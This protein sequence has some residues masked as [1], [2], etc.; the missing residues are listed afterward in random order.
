MDKES[1][2][3]VTLEDNF[4]ASAHGSKYKNKYFRQKDKKSRHHGDGEAR[5][6][7]GFVVWGTFKHA[8]RE[9]PATIEQLKSERIYGVFVNDKLEGWAIETYIDS[10]WR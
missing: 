10:G 2:I 6:S 8:V 7:N 3:L 5:Y 1:N 4:S 9:G